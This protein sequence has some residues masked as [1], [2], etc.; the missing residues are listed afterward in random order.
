MRNEVVIYDLEYTTWPGALERGW[1]GR[2]EHKEIT[3]LAAII[4]DA[5]TLNMI[6]SFSCIIR[7]T[8][9]PVLSDYFIDLTGLTNERL[10]SEGVS[11]FK[12]IQAFHYFV[13]DRPMMCHGWDTI[14]MLENF[15]LN[16]VAFRAIRLKD[17]RPIEI[18]LNKTDERRINTSIDGIEK[19]TLN[20][21]GSGIKIASEA[22]QG[23]IA[24]ELSLNKSSKLISSK[25]YIGYD[26]RPWFNENAPET[27]RKGSGELSAALGVTQIDGKLHEPLFDVRSL[28]EGARSLI[29]GRQ[30][31]NVFMDVLNKV[32][33]FY[34]TSKTCA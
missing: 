18:S 25:T 7:P 22:T 29:H 20:A 6:D 10:G 15:R 11:F 3:W 8:I 13:G 27:L 16:G 4:V 23:G 17:S 33:A 26:I 19:L 1:A 28:L 12:G 31:D 5:E 21:Y 2:D 14:S 32:S 9:N 24:Y 30:V 34:E